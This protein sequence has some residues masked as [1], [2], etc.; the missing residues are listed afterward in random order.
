VLIE[1]A[2]L[3]RDG[4]WMGDGQVVHFWKGE[5]NAHCAKDV[6]RTACASLRALE[7]C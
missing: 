4:W 7:I 1:E 2:E 3:G 6:R 5:S